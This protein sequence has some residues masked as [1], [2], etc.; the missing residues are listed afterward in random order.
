MKNIKVAL[1]VLIPS[2]L[3]SSCGS[4]ASPV[5]DTY[6]N[7][8]VDYAQLLDPA[9]IRGDDGKFY[10]YVTEG[11]QK[12]R[13]PDTEAFESKTPIYESTDMVNWSYKCD[14][15]SVD[16]SKNWKW[17]NNLSF[18]SPEIQKINGKYVFY[19]SLGRMG[20]SNLSGVGCATSDTPYGPWTH[21]DDPVITSEDVDNVDAIDPCVVVDDGKVYMFYG[22]YDGIGVIELDSTGTAVKRGATPK[23]VAGKHGSA[24][25]WNNYTAPYVVKIN[26]K[27]CLFVSNGEWHNVQPT[28]PNLYHTV[29][30]QST[31]LLGSYTDSQGRSAL[32][33]GNGDIVMTS[34]EDFMGPGNVCVIPDDGGNYYIYFHTF[35]GNK[36]S[37]GRYFGMEKLEINGEYPTVK[38]QVVHTEVVKPIVK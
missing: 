34:G 31:T 24:Q 1:L 20:G 16:E 32:E 4:G 29:V 11:N 13:G 15:V 28:T 21:I 3:L 12:W 36:T 19:Y 2:V 10:L 35:I 22:N 38:D 33:K 25:D 6:K 30:F 37:S 26:G 7:V 14:V 18:W 8:L 9:V 17:S 23:M 27:W 5:L